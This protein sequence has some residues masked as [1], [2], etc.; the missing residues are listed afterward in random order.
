MFTLE[1][2]EQNTHPQPRFSHLPLG[3]A[4]VGEIAET[5]LCLGV[6]YRPQ[7]SMEHECAH[8]ESNILMSIVYSLHMLQP[9]IYHIEMER[10]PQ[11]TCDSW[12]Q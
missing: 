2:E 10:R 8:V 9:H 6:N 1:E 3:P 5:G 11:Y 4:I 12:N 7:T